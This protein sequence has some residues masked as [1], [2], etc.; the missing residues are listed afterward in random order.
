MLCVL[1]F[2]EYKYILQRTDLQ[3]IYIYFYSF[4]NNNNDLFQQVYRKT[5]VHTDI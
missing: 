2:T 5:F 1:M 4:V 3:F